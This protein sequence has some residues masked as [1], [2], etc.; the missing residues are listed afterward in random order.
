M[1]LTVLVILVGMTTLVSGGEECPGCD[2]DGNGIIDK[3]I[4]DSVY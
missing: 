2:P 3:V 1:Q 4:I